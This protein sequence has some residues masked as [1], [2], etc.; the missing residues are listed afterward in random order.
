ML[1]SPKYV[2]LG[3][4]EIIHTASHSDSCS[5]FEAILSKIGDFHFYGGGLGS[6]SNADKS[7]LYVSTKRSTEKY[8]SQT[9]IPFKWSA[10]ALKMICALI[11]LI[12]I[13]VT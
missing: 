11:A 5:E 7:Q 1:D 3:I 4:V 6:N 13:P 8:S 2:F 9:Q 12:T 10:E